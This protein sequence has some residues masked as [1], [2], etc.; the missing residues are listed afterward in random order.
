MREKGGMMALSRYK[1]VAILGCGNIGLAI[2]NGLVESKKFTPAQIILTKRRLQGLKR[3]KEKGFNI[4][5]DNKKAVQNSRLIIISVLPSDIIGLLKEIK[6]VIK[7]T[8]HIIISVVTGATI[9]DI[10]DVL[11]KKLPIFR[12]MPNT[13]ISIKESMTC[14][15]YNSNGE[16]YIGYI[17][18]LFDCLGNTKVIPES[19]MIAATSLCACGVAFFL[20]GIRAAAQGG[21]EIGFHPED[22]IFMAAQTA[23]GAAKLLLEFN[24]HPEQEIDKVTTPRGCTIA[25][26]NEMEHEGF[27]SAMIKGIKTS[28]EKAAQLFKKT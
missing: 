3:L 26:L 23:L 9:T 28:A 13:A 21:I 8:K 16:K 18:E 2:A 5:D 27:S 20:R 1:G 17:K 25:G 12:A 7:T 6:P 4:T 24:H 10:Q 19:D 11:G 15:S 14:L 22:A